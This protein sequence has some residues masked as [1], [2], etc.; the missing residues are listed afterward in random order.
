MSASSASGAAPGLAAAALTLFALVAFRAGVRGRLRSAASGRLHAGAP[1]AGHPTAGRPAGV[2]PADAVAGAACGLGPRRRGRRRGGVAPLA[3]LAARL[4]DAGVAVAPEVVWRCWVGGGALAG[5]A[6]LLAAGPGAAGLVAGLVVAG[7]VLGWRLVRHR[8]AAVFEAALPAAVE[9]VAA[10]LRSGGSLRQALAGATG[11]GH[12]PLACDL[13]AVVAATERGAGVVASL[14]G[15]AERRPLPG[16][17]LV[18]AALCLGAETGGAAAQA[19]DG[20]AQTLR[21][22]L[23]TQAE[24]RAL[25]TQARVSAVVIGAAPVVFCALS[26]ATDP[27]SAAFLLRTPA[28]LALLATGLALD[29]AGALW[30][31]RLTRIEP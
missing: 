3:W 27:R 25:A 6:S 13:A 8:G 2:A 10:G 9:A 15:W 19:V 18:V 17:R 28:G 5:A 4:E 21:R 29:A 31:A 24:A 14:E 1:T 7:P 30:M 16:V 11:A 23:A 22:R 12:G 20:V 26:T